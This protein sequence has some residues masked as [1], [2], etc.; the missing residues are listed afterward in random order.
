MAMLEVSLSLPNPALE[1]QQPLRQQMT[2]TLT[3][4]HSLDLWQAKNIMTSDMFQFL[5]PKVEGPS[6][7]FL[8]RPEEAGESPQSRPEDLKKWLI[9]PSPPAIQLPARSLNPK[10]RCPLILPSLF[11]N[12]I[13][14]FAYMPLE[15]LGFWSLAFHFPERCHSSMK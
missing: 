12:E 13:R 10:Q 15:R 9:L 11:S 7:Y 4:G 2:V 14:E 3:N 6:G 5:S 1:N 8:M